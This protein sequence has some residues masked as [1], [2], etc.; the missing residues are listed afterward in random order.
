MEYENLSNLD[1]CEACRNESTPQAPNVSTKHIPFSETDFEWWWA[2]QNH[3][4]ELLKKQC[5]T[6]I[7]IY[8]LNP[9]LGELN[10]I[11]QHHVWIPHITMDGWMKMINQHP[12]F[13]GIDFL[14]SSELIDGIPAWISCTIYR[15]DRVIPITVKE[16]YLELKTEALIWE[17]IPRRLLRFRVLQQCARLALNLSTPEF[18]ASQ[19]DTAP[20]LTHKVVQKD[21]NRSSS[22][23]I[24]KEHLNMKGK[25][26]IT[27]SA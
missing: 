27:I 14:E 17:E 4:S 16:Y 3:S 9:L 25:E 10:I 26:P 1:N 13:C 8:E 6:L 24:L 23:E 2:Q 15:Q 21:I 11:Y 18:S 5:Q 20:I 22:M 12:A 7:T 19:C